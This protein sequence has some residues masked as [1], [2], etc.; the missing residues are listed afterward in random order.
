MNSDKIFYAT[1]GLVIIMLGISAII[2]LYLQMEILAIIM[3][4]ILTAGI[5]LAVAG[6]I[7]IPKSKNT[8]TLQMITGVLF[9]CISAGVLAVVLNLLNIYVALAIIIVIIGTSVST[10]GL[11]ISR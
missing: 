2:G 8:A 10:L 7:T 6:A 5:I 4:W 11:F 3:L 1:L 9:V